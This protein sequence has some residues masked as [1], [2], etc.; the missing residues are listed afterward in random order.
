MSESVPRARSAGLS[1]ETKQQAVLFEI[2]MFQWMIAAFSLLFAAFVKFGLSGMSIGAGLF[3]LISFGLQRLAVS[4]AS[5]LT[6]DD[7][8]EVSMLLR[9]FYG[10]LGS[11]IPIACMAAV[12]LLNR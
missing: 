11:C 12:M 10:V 4:V 2:F 3:F 1:P 6:R 7:R 9:M 8:A 5:P